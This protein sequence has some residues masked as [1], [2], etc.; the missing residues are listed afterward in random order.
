MKPADFD[1]LLA[2]FLAHAADKD[3]YV[4][5]LDRRR[6]SC[7]QPANPR[8]HRICLAQPLHSQSVDPPEVEALDGF[9]PKMTIIDLPSFKADPAPPWMRAPKR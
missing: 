1:T 6:R 9:V 3:L 5:D 8:H 4:Q 2:D 7:P